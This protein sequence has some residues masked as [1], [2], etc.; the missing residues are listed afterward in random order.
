MPDDKVTSSLTLPW[1]RQPGGSNQSPLYPVGHGR[2]PGDEKLGS[3]Q[4]LSSK[5]S[6][7]GAVETCASPNSATWYSMEPI[8]GRGLGSSNLTILQ[9]G[10]TLLLTEYA[11]H[12]NNRR[13]ELNEPKR[14]FMLSSSNDD[15][16]S[17]HSRVLGGFG[18]DS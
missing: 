17:V 2:I 10:N 1:H 15:H 16:T 8:F 12:S 18:T 9:M 14:R 3:W 11:D 6:E 13:N 7:A 5:L 4:A